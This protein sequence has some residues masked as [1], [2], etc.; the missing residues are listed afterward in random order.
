MIRVG[1]PDAYAD[2]DAEEMVRLRDA[3]CPMGHMGNAWDV[4]FAALFLGSDE[5]RYIT[6]TEIIVDGGITAKFG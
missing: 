6:G 2:G 1:L 3:Q 5:S 4:A